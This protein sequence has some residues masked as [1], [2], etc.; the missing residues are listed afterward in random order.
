MHFSDNDKKTLEKKLAIRSFSQ[1]EHDFFDTSYYNS[2]VDFFM[3][4]LPN[5]EPEILKL[6]YTNIDKVLQSGKEIVEKHTNGTDIRV[7]FS[8]GQ[9]FYTY[10]AEHFGKEPDK[11]MWVQVIEYVYDNIVLKDV[12]EIPVELSVF[13]DPNGATCWTWFY[14]KFH[15]TDFYK[16][17]PIVISKIRLKGHVNDFSVG[18]YVHEIYH[19]LNYR[20]KGYTSNELYDEVTSIFMEWVTALELGG[21]KLCVL[22]RLRRILKIKQNILYR[23]LYSYS[24]TKPLSVI[25]H[26]KYI[27]SALLASCLFDIYYNGNEN[28]KKGI[29]SDINSIF[30]SRYTLDDVLDKYE[31]TPEKGAVLIK[32]MTKDVSRYQ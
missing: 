14:D 16:Q 12:T 7:P 31:A 28:I 26:S 15:D 23:E 6:P 9:Y 21:D 24:D 32:K 19:A 3:H 4:N 22:S 2:L 1:Y 17:L 18:T 8:Y 27:I 20:N 10:L 25:D 30:S 29:D 5:L 13:C 11:D